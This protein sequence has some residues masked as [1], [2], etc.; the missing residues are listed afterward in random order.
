MAEIDT[1]RP[2]YFVCDDEPGLVVT[3]GGYPG[4]AETTLQDNPGWQ[5]P[6]G[7]WVFSGVGGDT[8]TITLYASSGQMYLT[9]GGDSPGDPV[10][11]EV[12]LPGSDAQMWR[13]HEYSN[14]VAWFANG[15]YDVVLAYLGSNA[16]PGVPLTLAARPDSHTTPETFSLKPVAFD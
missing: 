4:G 14:G 3:A 7:M 11:I 5:H 16:V 2:Q 9:A 8:Y 10:T 1:T 15:G 13:L 6:N 12:V